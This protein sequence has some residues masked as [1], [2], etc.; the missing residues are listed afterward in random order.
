M[1]AMKMLLATQL[2]H[3]NGAPIRFPIKPK[4]MTTAPIINMKMKV[5][6]QQLSTSLLLLDKLSMAPLPSI[7]I[8]GATRKNIMLS[9]IPGT[10]KAKVPNT[11][12]IIVIIEAAS[13]ERSLLAVN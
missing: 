12:N 5:L 1:K 3:P 6:N 9:I 4:N 10:I 8:V 11:I 2:N 13:N 7:I